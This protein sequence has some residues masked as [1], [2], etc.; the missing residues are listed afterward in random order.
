[1][2]CSHNKPLALSR[3]SKCIAPMLALL[4]AFHPAAGA[5]QQPESS[6]AAAA[7]TWHISG[8]AIDARSGQALARC[9]IEIHSTD[10]RSQSLSLETGEDGRFDFGG[11][12]LGKY[13]LNAAKRGYLTQSYQEHEGFSTA[14]AVGPERKSDDLIFKVTPQ[15][16]FYGTVSDETGEPIRRAQVRLYEDRDMDGIRSTQQGQTVSTDDRGVY[17]M[18]NI[19]PGNYFLS[20]SA[21]PWYAAGMNGVHSPVQSNDGQSSPDSALDVAYPTIFYPGA[22]DSDDAIPIPIRGGERIEANMTLTAQRAMHLHLALVRG[23]EGGAQV[24]IERTVFGQ[25]ERMPTLQMNDEGGVEINGVLP[26]RYEVAVSHSDGQSPPESNHFTADIADGATQLSA[27]GGVGDVTVS[28]KVTPFDSKIRSASISLVAASH[29]RRNYTVPVNDAGEFTAQVAPGEYE[30]TGQIAQMYVAGISS[31]NALV[32]GL[33]LQVNAG[34]APR[35][36]IVAGTGYGQIE[37]MAVRAGHP[38]SG[39]MIL[40]APEDAKDN[41][42]LFRRDQ[43]DSDGTFLLFN[44][45]PGR[46]RL[47]AIDD[48]WE[49]N[50]ADPNVL[51]AYLKKSI[52]VHVRVHDKLKQM[53]EVQ[54]R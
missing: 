7:Q 46:Y 44:I 23:Q 39:I 18:P 27:E 21:Q 26:G 43:S 37:G 36:E 38:A 40:L 4:L 1:M 16:I 9:V 50:W 28:G 17:E 25:L 53:V 33:M 32:K 54:S 34:A 14:I 10:N 12:R 6:S 41:Q 8:R 29:P 52:T 30:V 22:I 49:L 2:Y 19:G 24:S 15:A 31:P 11:V 51:A 45:V 20:A 35:L 13:E 42:I 47:L 3:S 5:A 48:G